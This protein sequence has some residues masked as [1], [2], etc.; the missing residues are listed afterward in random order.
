MLRFSLLPLFLSAYETATLS[1]HASISKYEVCAFDYSHS[2]AP[3]DLIQVVPQP[4]S[5]LTNVRYPRILCFVNTISTHLERAQAVAGTWGQR[6]D[7]LIFFS[8]VSGSGLSEMLN[9]EV[10]GLDVNSDHNHLWGKHKASLAYVHTHFRH[11]YDWFYKADDDAY[12]IME[13]LK[14]YLSQPEI[15]SRWKTEP[16]QLGHRLRLENN[17]T[18]YYIVER[19]LRNDFMR[20]YGRLIFNGGGPG[21][22]LNRMFLDNVVNSFSEYDCFSQKHSEMI[23]DDVAISFCMAWKDNF[24]VE[25]RD[26]QGRERWHVDSLDGAYHSYLYDPNNWIFKFHE[27]IGGVRAR[28]E[29]CAPDSVAMHYV[30]PNLMYH[31]ERQLYWCR[32]GDSDT[33]HDYNSKFNYSISEK[34]MEI[35]LE[36]D[37]NEQ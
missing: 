5:I 12:V 33:M 14:N 20:K 13:N 35:P 1:G 34:I 17:I 28:N 7:K 9:F 23:P 16:M 25:T 4:Q 36:A 37:R 24:P 18:Q 11:S 30:T 29:C 15:Y 2:K 8:N 3:L 6:C 19:A 27:T 26:Y 10:I 31:Y 22:A 32:D 21:Y